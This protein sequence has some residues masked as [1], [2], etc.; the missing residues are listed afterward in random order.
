MEF[1]NIPIALTPFHTERVERV[2]QSLR[3]PHES[4]GAKENNCP[5]IGASCRFH[6]GS[7]LR[8]Y[9]YVVVFELYQ[10]K[11]ACLYR[12][13]DPYKFMADFKDDTI[14]FERCL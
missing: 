14:S 8:V 13:T 1:T 5:E 12:V 11:V 6:L 10:L 3:S 4:L 9:I 2:C 7:V